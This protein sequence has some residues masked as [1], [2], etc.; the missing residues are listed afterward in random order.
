MDLLQL[1]RVEDRVI[2]I[3]HHGQ[4]HRVRLRRGEGDDVVALDADRLRIRDPEH[5][6]EEAANRHLGELPIPRPLDVV[7]GQL[8]APVRLDPLL[9]RERRRRAVGGELPA[10]RELPL[11]RPAVGLVVVNR[12]VLAKDIRVL[13]IGD[14]LELNEG[15]VE[16]PDRVRRLDVHVELGV[17]RRGCAG[18]CNDEGVGRGLGLGRAGR[19]PVPAASPPSS[20]PPQ[21]ERRPPTAVAP[22]IMPRKRRRLKPSRSTLCR[23]SIRSEK[24]RGSGEAACPP[25]LYWAGGLANGEGSGRTGAAHRGPVDGTGSPGCCCGRAARNE[26]SHGCSRLR[27]ARRRTA[28]DTRRRLR[29]TRPLIE[30]TAPRQPDAALESMGS[31]GSMVASTLSMPSAIR[32]ASL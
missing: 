32:S 24:L 10:I 3:D 14:R 9:Q 7:R 19:R 21:A 2:E 22:A 17:Q 27:R 13:G 8:V 11:D 26:C 31:H 30:E 28:V 6:E 23:Y 4:E 16:H 29:N 20:P 15:V 18:R 5:A 25:S 12:E 1:G